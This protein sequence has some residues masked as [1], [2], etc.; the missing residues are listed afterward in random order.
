MLTLV[1]KKLKEKDI[2]QT[3][4]IKTTISTLY[5]R[6]ITKYKPLQSI[7]NSFPTIYWL[8]RNL[9]SHQATLDSR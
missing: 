5:F 7:P 8:D 1:F 9:T 3:I 2:H 6:Y 4:T